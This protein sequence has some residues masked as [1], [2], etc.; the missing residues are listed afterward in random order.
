M[1]SNCRTVRDGGE[2]GVGGAGEGEG[3]AMGLLKGREGL[4]GGAE[5]CPSKLN[6]PWPLVWPW[7]GCG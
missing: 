2:A 5:G 7:P 4:A 1:E 6:L 3:W